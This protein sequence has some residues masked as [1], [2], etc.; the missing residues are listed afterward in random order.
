[1]VFDPAFPEDWILEQT[2]YRELGR[3]MTSDPKNVSSSMGL[4]TCIRT[5]VCGGRG[6]HDA[7]DGTNRPRR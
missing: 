5:K 7:V 2:R 4:E 6:E 3:A 1:M